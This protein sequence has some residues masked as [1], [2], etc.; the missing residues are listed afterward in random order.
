M[1]GIC[2]KITKIANDNIEKT[3]ITL[4]QTSDDLTQLGMDS[5]TF[6]RIIVALE[7]EFDIEIPDENLLMPELNTILKMVNVVTAVLNTKV[8]EE[9]WSV[10]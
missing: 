8:Q 5:I 4:A 6:I 9:V 2:D 10:N 1:N 7:E 3:E